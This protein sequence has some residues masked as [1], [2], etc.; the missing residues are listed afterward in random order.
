MKW[1]ILFTLTLGFLCAC[2]S[3]KNQITR[4]HAQV[5]APTKGIEPGKYPL[6]IGKTLF[7]NREFSWRDGLLYVP[8]GYDPKV[9]AP[10]MVWLHGGGGHAHTSTYMFP[11]ADQ[12]GI[13]LLA[14]DSRHNT[15]DGIDSTFGPD[16]VFIEKALKHVYDRVAIDKKKL[17]LG[18]LSDGGSYALAIGRANGDL[19]THL[20]A[21]APWHLKPPSPPT[22]KPSILVVHGI[23]DRVYPYRHSR[24]CLVP[25]LKKA[26]YRVE[27]IQFDGPH[28]V[29]EPTLA[30]VFEWLIRTN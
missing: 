4:I 12:F 23:Q 8:K 6:G 13:V 30:Q 14:I 26:G 1:F 19:F 17:A 21:A 22:G 28:W 9:P 11:L 25:A 29:P 10:L 24:N 15:W 2:D 3:K 27:Y 18:G 16:V 20:I 7:I 5:T